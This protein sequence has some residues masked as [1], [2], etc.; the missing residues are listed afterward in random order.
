MDY[1]ELL[2]SIINDDLVTFEKL[3]RPNSTYNVCF[4]RFPSLSL[5]YLYGAVTILKT[6]EGDMLKYSDGEYI[7][8]DESI[9]IYEDFKV[10]AEKC[11]RFYLN[12][13]KVEPIEMLA[14]L[15]KSSHLKTV[16]GFAPKKAEQLPLIEK[17]YALKFDAE[18]LATEER[19]I[20][21]DIKLKDEKK[22]VVGLWAIGSLCVTLVLAGLLIAFLFAVGV[23]TQKM[24]LNVYTGKALVA[25]AGNAD[26]IKLCSDVTVTESAEESS[27]VIDGDGHTV[28]LTN[29]SFIETFK[30][31]MK[32]VR[33]VFSVKGKVED[34]LAIIIDNQG[35]L[36]SITVVSNM[37]FTEDTSADNVYVCALTVNNSGE[38]SNCEIEISAKGSSNGEG[39]AYLSGL[40]A[41]N[42]GKLTDVTV[43][44]SL[45]AD[46]VDAAG[47]CVENSGEIV[48][49]Y[50]YAD[51]SQTSAYISNDG[52]DASAYSLWNPN[53]AG[54]VL[55]NKNEGS[56]YGCAN[57]GNVGVVSTVE[58][59]KGENGS[60]LAV[61]EAFS[62]GVV[63]INLGAVGHSK[64]LGEVSVESVDAYAY[65]GG[66][67]ACNTTS[68]NNIFTV[69]GVVDNCYS[70]G[71]IAVNTQALTLAGGIV[72][73]N[74]GGVK[75]SYTDCE[76]EKGE[77]EN[78]AIG[79]II[80]MDLCDVAFGQIVYNSNVSSN[81]SVAKD[82]APYAIGALSYRTMMGVT[83]NVLTSENLLYVDA[84]GNKYI[85]QYNYAIDSLDLIKDS[86]GY[87]E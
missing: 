68:Q 85:G 3:T 77:N 27:S 17:I 75:S 84:N 65:V 83:Q 11:L 31:E 30:G 58:I 32:N 46:T 22:R 24:P 86:E 39:N 81:Y 25:Q 72:G 66:V 29:T 7:F 50:N 42:S 79:G 1:N 8:A 70:K 87:W 15:G 47:V 71:K 48:N 10:V 35:K 82:S 57:Y 51:V 56:V 23:G 52:E 13:K 19:I 4:G 2:N 69:V 40:C 38:I 36:S 6:H 28:T 62:G 74:A 55:T 34:D 61:S 44:G 9:K 26:Y 12:G 63:A 49:A 14:I 73:Y 67:V 43:R 76:Y 80:G 54:V 45:Q 60:P 33:F 53:C 64:N 41:T 5:C 16:W 21:P 18:C 20:V 59:P 37:D 78:Q